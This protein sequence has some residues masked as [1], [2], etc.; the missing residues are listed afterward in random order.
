MNEESFEEQQEALDPHRRE[1][2]DFAALEISGRL[3]QKGVL[4]TGRETS[5]QLDDLMHGLRGKIF[6]AGP[7]VLI[8]TAHHTSYNGLEESLLQ[9]YEGN[10]LLVHSSG[11]VYG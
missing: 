1:E 2:R 4:L 5:S 7:Y 10:P 9:E 6:A 3:R 8:K 11:N